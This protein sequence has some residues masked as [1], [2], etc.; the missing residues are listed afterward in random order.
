MPLIDYQTN[1]NTDHDIAR[2]RV[3]AR[4]VKQYGYL[5]VYGPTM[6]DVTMAGKCFDWIIAKY[7]GY[8][9]V[10]EF[11]SG[12]LTVVNESLDPD[13]GFRI[14]QNRLDS[15]G[16]V[17]QSFAGKLLEQFNIHRGAKDPEELAEKDRNVRGN[18][19]RA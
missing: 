12:V 1:L 7:P 11:R 16:K 8:R 19:K 18:I 2:A 6:A 13:W 17:V 3:A 9:W 14:K 10:V 4:L 5:P 15:D